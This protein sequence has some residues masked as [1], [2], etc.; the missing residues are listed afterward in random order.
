MCEACLEAEMA[1]GVEH[2][3]SDERCDLCGGPCRIGLLVA[4]IG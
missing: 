2:E 1:K 3:T 4:Y